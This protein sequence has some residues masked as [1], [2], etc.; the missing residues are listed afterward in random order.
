MNRSHARFPWAATLLIATI[1]GS[2]GIIVTVA[3]RTTS[4]LKGLEGTRAAS[5]DIGPAPPGAE[6]TASAADSL[7]FAEATAAPSLE[8]RETALVPWGPVALP[9]TPAPIAVR[10]GADET[11]EDVDRDSSDA[12]PDPFAQLDADARS[13][14]SRA[15]QRAEAADAIP[16][17]ESYRAA[18]AEWERALPL[19]HGDAY[20]T[21]CLRLAEAR[22]RGWQLEPS[23]AGRSNVEAAIG[24]FLAVAHAGP[25]R[26]GAAH[27][28]SRVRETGSR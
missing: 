17:P 16:S 1:A 7:R 12:P 19:L 2:L 26:D 15:R 20:R 27:W 8:E 25:E 18:A 9:E 4:W 14:V 23:R 24:A 5:P 10:I 21:A 3:G 11:A 13:A 28:L 6:A 22:Y